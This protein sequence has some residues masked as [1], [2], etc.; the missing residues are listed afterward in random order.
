MNLDAYI[1]RL[2][3]I[4]NQQADNMLILLPHQADL[5]MMAAAL[6]FYSSLSQMGKQVK[7]VCPEKI[8]VEKSNLVGVSKITDNL[9]K[10][11]KNLIIS[12]PYVEGSIEKVSYNIQNQRFN[13]VIEPKGD[14]LIFRQD[15]VEFS[16]GGGE[17]DNF[18]LI[19][20]I[21]VSE[22]ASLGTFQRPV[23]KLLQE[24]TAVI[25]NN[26][27]VDFDFGTLRIINP[28]NSSLSEMMVLLL[29][30][31]NLPFDQ[32][33]AGNLLAGIKEKTAN[34]SQNVT[35]DSFE[36]AA[37][38]MRKT[39]TKSFVSSYPFTGATSSDQRKTPPDWLKPKIFRSSNPTNMIGNNNKGIIF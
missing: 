36:A 3:T 32:D 11:G 5:D 2:Q 9:G 27:P 4:L 24:K 28:N 22:M 37:I 12:F 6:A 8:T 13:L 10:E 34:F 18:D 31:L 26:K 1:Y 39:V 33:I 19:F 30:G 7:I 20:T 21:G 35:A 25:I 16:W 29:S 14:K 23:E 15:Q 38:C 17:V